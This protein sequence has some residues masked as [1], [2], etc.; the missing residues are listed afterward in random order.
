[1][2]HHLYD[3][4]LRYVLLALAAFLANAKFRILDR[5]A[6]WRRL[7][8]TKTLPGRAGPTVQPWPVLG[9]GQTARR[10]HDADRRLFVPPA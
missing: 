8:A 10:R 2:P 5:R 7:S 6:L 1:M 3:T 9:R 4:L